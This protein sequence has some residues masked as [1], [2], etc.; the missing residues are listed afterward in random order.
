MDFKDLD[1]KHS[2]ISYGEENIISSLVA[3]SLRYAKSY[4]RSV[5]FFSSSVFNVLADQ[6]ISLV[7]NQ[8][9]IKMICGPQLSE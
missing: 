1:I 9:K 7:R 2:Y 8:G 4:K 6:I 5:G 3:P